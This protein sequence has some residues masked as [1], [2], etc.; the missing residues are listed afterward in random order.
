MDYFLTDE[1]VMIKDLAKKIAQEKIIPVRAKYDE[2]GEFPWEI[3]KVIA[4]ADPH[5]AIESDDLSQVSP[6]ALRPAPIDACQLDSAFPEKKLDDA[7]THL[8]CAQND[9]FQGI[10]HGNV[11]LVEFSSV[12]SSKQYAVRSRQ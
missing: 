11:L 4:E 1:Q 2:S 9:N 12:K 3:I 8:A 10:S 5:I 7:R 6:R